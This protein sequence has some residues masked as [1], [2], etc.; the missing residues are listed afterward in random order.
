[1]TQRELISIADP[2]S[3]TSA[4]IA[5]WRGALVTSFK[6]RGQDVLY[7]DRETFDDPQKNVRGGIPI[8]FPSP[9]KLTDDRWHCDGRSGAMKQHGFARTKV[10]DAIARRPHSVTLQ[11]ESDAETLAQYPWAFRA[12]FEVSVSASRLRL[13]MTIENRDQRP[14]PFAFGYHPYFAVDRKAKSTITSDAT[15]VFDNV[16]KKA[17]PFDGR[18]DLTREELDLHLLDQTAHY[19]TLRREEGGEIEVCASDDFAYWVVWSVKG[20]GFVCVEPWTS[21]P[22]ALNG[23]ERL[24]R[25]GVGERWRAVVEVGFR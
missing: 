24:L 25:L 22:N 11:L 5:P 1:M 15:R 10:W 4:A 21:P 14:M 16:T 7:L 13:D 18:F 20:K 9:G 12:V 17:E 8:L 23:G 19:M 6:V 3:D 2:D